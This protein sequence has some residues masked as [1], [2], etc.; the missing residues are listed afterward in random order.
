MSKFATR[1]IN[2]NYKTF[3]ENMADRFPGYVLDKDGFIRNK[4]DLCVNMDQMLALLR[5]KDLA[6]YEE[7]KDRFFGNQARYVTTN[8]TE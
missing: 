6:L 4:D 2:E 8:S 5:C 1:K 7:V 3:G